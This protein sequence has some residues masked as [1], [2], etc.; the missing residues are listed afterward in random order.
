[1]LVHIITIIV[2]WLARCSLHDQW[3][4]TCKWY[5]LIENA[6]HN[7]ITHSITVKMKEIYAVWTM[8]LCTIFYIYVIVLRRSLY[9]KCIIP[10]SP[11]QIN[12]CKMNSMH[13]EKLVN[14]LCFY[15]HINKINDA[16]DLCTNS[17]ECDVAMQARLCLLSHSLSHSFV[18]LFAWSI[19][20]I[21]LIINS[22][23]LNSNVMNIIDTDEVEPL[24]L[25]D[26]SSDFVV[27]IVTITIICSR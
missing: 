26:G 4:W 27:F 25:G 19:C 8:V 13:V 3:T 16:N 2:I 17:N 14:S 11:W 6:R 24:F 1:M 10:P 18:C 22:V 12:V 7:W 20:S 21:A 15:V 5:T 23:K 9:R